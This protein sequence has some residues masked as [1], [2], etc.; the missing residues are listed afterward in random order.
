M[1]SDID[2]MSVKNI[3]R[4][5]FTSIFRNLWRHLIMYIFRRKQIWTVWYNIQHKATSKSWKFPTG[6]H[7]AVAKGVKKIPVAINNRPYMYIYSDYH[8]GSRA[9]MMYIDKAH[10]SFVTPCKRMFHPRALSSSPSFRI[11]RYSGG[12]CFIWWK[13]VFIL[14]YSIPFSPKHPSFQSW[15]INRN[16]PG[17]GSTKYSFSPILC[18]INKDDA[19]T[20]IKVCRNVIN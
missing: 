19:G 10:N 15:I 9:R 14:F 17:V 16:M 20:S 3:F 13:R 2:F 4:E 8:A 18:A 12:G 7:S 5:T 11:S 6:M 1:Q